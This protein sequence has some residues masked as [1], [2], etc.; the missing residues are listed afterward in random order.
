MRSICVF[1]GASQG[2]NPAYSEASE[3][4]GRTLAQQNIELVWGAENIGLMGQLA[5]SV[6]ATGG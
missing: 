5:D 2:N 6:L 3:E 1:C 4:L